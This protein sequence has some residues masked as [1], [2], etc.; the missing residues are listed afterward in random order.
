MGNTFEQSKRLLVLCSSIILICFGCSN[1]SN[2]RSNKSH[3]I[4]VESIKKLIVEGRYREA[5]YRINTLIGKEKISPAIRAE[6]FNQKGTLC[7]YMGRYGNSIENY[8]RALY[9]WIQLKNEPKISD[10]YNNLFMVC[11]EIDYF[12]KSKYYLVKTSKSFRNFK[13]RHQ[14]KMSYRIN[15]GNYF[16]KRQQ[17]KKAISAYKLALFHSSHLRNK[18]FDDNI[19]NNLGV[20]YMEERAYNRSK[21]YFL[22]ALKGYQNSKDQKGI[23]LVYNN[24]GSLEAAKKSN[25]SAQVYFSKALKYYNQLEQQV[26]SIAV[27][28]NLAIS[29]IELGE[30]NR[31]HQYLKSA[32]KIATALSS[33]F[34]LK[35]IYSTWIKLDT[36]TNNYL[37][38]YKH[39]NQ[40]NQYLEQF[41]KEQF[42]KQL[43]NA[44]IRHQIELKESQNNTLNKKLE[45]QRLRVYSFASTSIALIIVL[46]IFWRYYKQKTLNRSLIEKQLLFEIQELKNEVLI[47]TSMLDNEKTQSSWDKSVIEKIFDAKINESD[48]QILNILRNDPMSNNAQIA[49]AVNLSIEGV[50]SSLKKMYR[51]ANLE[52][53]SENQ[54]LSLIRFVLKSLSDTTPS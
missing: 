15:L 13:A 25:H 40:F 9:I 28:R 19:Y 29:S 36:T 2:I 10:A 53:R 54:R 26:Y 50:R 47:R 5:D 14:A 52:K 45:I 46:F 49:E 43:Q 6:L 23:A 11:N 7:F 12:S 16:Y 42:E 4:H 48:W 38:A 24:L 34:E 35:E 21:L 8:K 17:Y 30:L 39:Q 20:A 22:K 41:L 32:R 44:K 51:L 3:L 37:E 18:S 27:Y 31:A 33:R 1:Q